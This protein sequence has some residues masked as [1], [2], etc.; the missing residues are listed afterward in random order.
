[1]NMDVGTIHGIWTI[2]VMVVFVWIVI[3]AWSSKRKKEFDDAAMIPFNE[4]KQG[5]KLTGQGNHE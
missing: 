4:D 1:M 2:I 3:W 5:E